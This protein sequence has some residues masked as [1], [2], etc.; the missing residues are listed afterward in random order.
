MGVNN[1]G[2]M[3]F[4]SNGYDKWAKTYKN[5]SDKRHE[6]FMHVCTLE[7]EGQSGSKNH[8]AWAREYTTWTKAKE[9]LEDSEPKY[10]KKYVD[11]QI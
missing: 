4:F 7:D 1:G 2:Y 3:G 9:M 5:A 10:F 6:A 11:N 8:Q